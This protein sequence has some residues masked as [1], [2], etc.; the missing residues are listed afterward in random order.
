MT[1]LKSMRL[2]LAALALT[3]STT[4][5]AS[6]PPLSENPRVVQE[7]LAV[8]VGDEI[9]KNCPT[10][11]ARLFY[12]LRKAG[13]LQDYVQ[14]LGYTK[15]DIDAMRKDPANKARLKAMRDE[16]LTANGVVPGDQDS[17]CRLGRLEI[18][19]KT[20]VGSLIWS[21]E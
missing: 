7:F 20:L 9:R 6:L 4:M 18:E 21:R 5:A 16:Y 11:S 3:A 14:G 19:G 8:A 1:H 13:D 15:D 10:I 12:V 2:G 17:Y